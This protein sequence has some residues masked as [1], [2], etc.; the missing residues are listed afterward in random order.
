[1]GLTDIQ[2]KGEK[3]AYTLYQNMKTMGVII[4]QP[5]LNVQLGKKFKC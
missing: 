3:F 4:K 5:H 1:M 2:Y